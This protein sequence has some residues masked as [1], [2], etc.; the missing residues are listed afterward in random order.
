M[1]TKP[2]YL[3]VA[4]VLLLLIVSTRLYHINAFPPFIDEVVH[5]DYAHDIVTSGPF[6]HADEGRQFAL[7]WYVVTGATANQSVAVARLGNIVFTLLTASAM[8]AAASTLA[9]RWSG[10]AAGALYLVSPFQLFFDRLV[11]VDPVSTAGVMLAIAFAARLKKRQNPIDA[12]LCGVSLAFAVGAKVSALPYLG[13]PLAAILT[14]KPSSV[15][16]LR[17][18]LGWFALAEIVASALSVGFLLLI[19]LRGLDPFF[20]LTNTSGG[21]P[22]TVFRVNVTQSLDGVVGF[23][24][25]VGAI[26]LIAGVGVLMLR[27]QWF[28][29]LCLLAPLFVLWFSPRQG[30]RHLTT[31]SAILLLCAAVAIPY[32]WPRY[33]RQIQ[34]AG[35]AVFAI[36]TVTTAMPFAVTYY[37]NPAQTSLPSLDRSEYLLSSSAGTGLSEIVQELEERGAERVIGLLANCHGLRYLAAGEF[38]VICPNINPNSDSLEELEALIESSHAKGSYMVIEELDYVPQVVSGAEIPIAI[39]PQR[40][41]LRLYALALE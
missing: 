18:R 27:R 34:R 31:P 32:I 23:F 33:T 4:T 21:E 20:Y 13:I 12:I 1:L 3:L 39:P 28:L 19:Y 22:L 11:L 10:L 5:L 38:E 29:P 36:F 26:I 37:S 25:I 17:Q 7:W 41:V 40:N 8:M 35:V 30:S 15:S 6:S 14:L 16:T 24:G 2:R 9:G